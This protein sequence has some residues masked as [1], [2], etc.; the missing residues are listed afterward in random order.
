[1][2]DALE[3]QDQSPWACQPSQ[4]AELKER[5]GCTSK[6]HAV[7]WLEKWWTTHSLVEDHWNVDYVSLSYLAFWTCVHGTAVPRICAFILWILCDYVFAQLRY[8]K[9]IKKST[10]HALKLSLKDLLWW[11]HFLVCCFVHYVESGIMS[12]HSEDQ[13]INIIFYFLLL[14]IFLFWNTRSSHL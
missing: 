4:R 5:G 6:H 14:P 2:W 1:M 11:H 9:L 7:G 12:F 13:M 3:D 10:E 8:K